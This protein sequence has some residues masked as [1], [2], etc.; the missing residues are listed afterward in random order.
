M[1]IALALLALAGTVHAAEIDA[2]TGLVKADG[3]LQVRAH[4]GGCHSH[5]LV[6][7]QRADRGTWLEIIRWMQATQNLWQFDP[8]TEEAILDYLAANYPPQ[9]GRRR[10]PIPPWL[11]PPG[12]GGA[13]GASD[14]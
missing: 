2:Q 14:R 12:A 6:T 8:A 3:W 5:R 13:S 1:R 10:A 9:P 4:C 7:S 11:M